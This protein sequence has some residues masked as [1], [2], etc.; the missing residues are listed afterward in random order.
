MKKQESF[1]FSAAL[2]W[3]DF[4]RHGGDNRDAL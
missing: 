4:L 2:A 1:R 3:C